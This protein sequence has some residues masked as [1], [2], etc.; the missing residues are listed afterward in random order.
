MGNHLKTHAASESSHQKDKIYE[1]PIT[2]SE[3]QDPNSTDEGGMPRNNKQKRLSI[4]ESL[5][6]PKHYYDNLSLFQLLI[7]YLQ[8]QMVQF[9]LLRPLQPITELKEF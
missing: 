5:K 3:I 8:S 2:D 4:T 1:S 7:F 9:K 6:N